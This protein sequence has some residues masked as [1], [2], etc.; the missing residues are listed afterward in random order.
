[1]VHDAIEKYASFKEI[2]VTQAGGTICNHCGPN[3][4]GVLFIRKA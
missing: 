2:L 1:M 4:L 3:T